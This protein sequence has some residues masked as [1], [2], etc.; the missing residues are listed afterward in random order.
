MDKWNL[1]DTVNS[2]AKV[3]PNVILYPKMVIKNMKAEC[4]FLVKDERRD[5]GKC[6]WWN[7]FLGTNDG[8]WCMPVF[9]IINCG[10]CHHKRNVI[11]MVFWSLWV[12]CSLNGVRV[13]CVWICKNASFSVVSTS[14]GNE[15]AAFCT[16]A[17]SCFSNV[18]MWLLSCLEQYFAEWS[19]MLQ[20]MVFILEK[21]VFFCWC[22]LAWKCFAIL[23]YAL[24]K[25]HLNHIK[26]FH[27]LLCFAKLCRIQY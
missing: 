16:I 20:H 1:T 12:E 23:S 26:P 3:C 4:L 21:K 11:K 18:A 7:L 25:L 13:Q 9:G 17:E 2:I 14:Y 5:V 27:H 19:L 22:A 15:S 8:I 24:D 6:I 10:F